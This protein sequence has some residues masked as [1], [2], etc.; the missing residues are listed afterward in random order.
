MEDFSYHLNTLDGAVPSE[1]EAYINFIDNATS[2][3]DGYGERHHVLPQSLFPEFANRSL[4]PWNSK[5][6]HL[7]DHLLAHYLLCKALP[8]NTSMAY[9]LN[10]MV[11]RVGES[12]EE[13]VSTYVSAKELLAEDA[14]VLRTGSKQSVET[15]NKRTSKTQGQK[16]TPEQRAR[17]SKA[18]RGVKHKPLSE[19][20]KLAISKRFKG[21]PNSELTKQRKSIALTGKPKSKEAVERSVAAKKRNKLMRLMETE[22]SEVA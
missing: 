13:M 21:V 20:H 9:A 18:M 6:L 2:A 14:R 5:R 19:A 22:Q 4:H 15:I 7:V 8:T 17:M 12:I 10:Q 1:V 3:L 11:G 16:R